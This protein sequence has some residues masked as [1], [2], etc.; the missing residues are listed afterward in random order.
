LCRTARMVTKIVF[1]STFKF[2]LGHTVS[3]GKVTG[4][5]FRMQSW[6]VLIYS[7]YCQTSYRRG[8][9]LMYILNVWIN[10][11]VFFL[12]IVAQK[13]KGRLTIEPVR[14]STTRQ[15][16]A[17]FSKCWLIWHAIAMFVLHRYCNERFSIIC[18]VVHAFVFYYLLLHFISIMSFSSRHTSGNRLVFGLMWCMD[19]YSFSIVQ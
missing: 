19:I 16:A 4:W 11:E 14:H 15:G 7:I 1:E 18:I 17:F 5:S 12:E 13:R 6:S 3:Y 9:K 8:L 2:V 10:V